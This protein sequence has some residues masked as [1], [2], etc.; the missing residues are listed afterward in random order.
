[1]TIGLIH[2]GLMDHL[3]S[4]FQIGPILYLGKEDLRIQTLP[5]LL[6]N[7]VPNP[8][9]LNDLTEIAIILGLQM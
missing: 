7:L 3:D 6:D 4:N 1:M 2:L 8:I 5:N 9:D